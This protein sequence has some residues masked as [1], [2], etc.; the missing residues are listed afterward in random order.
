MPAF[1]FYRVILQV[2]NNTLNILLIFA[3]I[4]LISIYSCGNM[5]LGAL[6][7]TRTL[8]KF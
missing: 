4:A 2:Q 6:R 3:P 8:R 7:C 1:F 5:N